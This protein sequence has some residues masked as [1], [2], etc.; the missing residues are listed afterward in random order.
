MLNKS[1]I[2]NLK[3]VD[4]DRYRA[5]MFADRQNRADLLVIYAFHA[6]LAKV[7][8]IVSEPMIG[9]IRYQWWRDA[10][11]EIFGKKP[12]RKH[13]VVLPL[14]EVI[15]RKALSRYHLDQLIAGRERDLDPTPFEKLEDARE[16]CRATSGLLMRIAVNCCDQNINDHDSDIIAGL[17]EIW[18]LTGLL[19]SWRHY[20]GSML[21]GIRRE[22][23]LNLTKNQYSEL[24]RSLGQANPEMI[25]AMAYLSLVPKFINQMSEPGFDPTKDAIN[26]S[27]LSKQLRLMRTILTGHL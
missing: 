7:P 21:S 19:R 12:I 5:A 27:V 2:N 1:V 6:E 9:A 10:L 4:P 20:A 18:G 3:R 11:G 24:S 16:Y 13:E 8:E 14:A 25:P 17:G 23:L 26:Y 15:K 22:D